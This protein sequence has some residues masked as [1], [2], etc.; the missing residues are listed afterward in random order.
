MS[1]QTT[2]L[3]ERSRRSLR[4]LVGDTASPTD[5]EHVW[6]VVLGPHEALVSRTK[7]RGR[8]VSSREL[9]LRLAGAGIAVEGIAAI[10]QTENH[11]QL[12]A[13]EAASQ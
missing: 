1:A 2:K 4:K 13:H 5:K 11:P 12:T 8:K 7:V 10:P 6:V 9:R 3:S